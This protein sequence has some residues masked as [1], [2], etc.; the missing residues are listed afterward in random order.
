[1]K[2]INLGILT[3]ILSNSGSIPLSHLIEII[4]PTADNLFLLTG[5]AGY[6][7][8]KTDKRLKVYE[9]KNKT[10]NNLMGRVFEYFL[11]Q[12]K[13]SYKMLKIRDLDI[14]IFFYWW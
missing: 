10:K 13:I 9:I 7:S 4:V 2:K 5:G 8:F 1:M 11:T 12:I 14:W 3:F 6:E